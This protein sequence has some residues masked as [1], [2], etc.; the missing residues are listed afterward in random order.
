MRVKFLGNEIRGVRRHYAR[1]RMRLQGGL[2]QAVKIIGC[3]ERGAVNATL[4]RASRWIVSL[5]LATNS[6]IV[7]GDLKGIRGRAKGKGKRLNRMVSNMPY[8]RLTKMIGYKATLVGIP[9]ITTSGAYT[10]KTCH[11]CGCG[12]K[13]KTQG[14]FFCPHCGSEYSAGLNGTINIAKKLGGVD[15]IHAYPLGYMW[16]SP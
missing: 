6:Y 16:T 5:S 4:H 12:G 13:R 9:V 10:S 8:Y 7:L 2:T 15:G 3:K 14:L 11:I 1:L